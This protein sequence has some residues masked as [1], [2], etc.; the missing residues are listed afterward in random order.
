MRPANVAFVV[1]VALADVWVQRVTAA[2]SPEWVLIE[3]F[4]KH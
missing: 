3:V 2:E 4:I 1:K